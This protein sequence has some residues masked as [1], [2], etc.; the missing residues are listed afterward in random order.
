[1]NLFPTAEE[2]LEYTAAAIR[3]GAVSCVA[4]VER[5]LAAIDAREAEVKAWVS[6][7][8]EGALQRARELD[9]EIAR[10]NWVGPL[11]G[12]PVGIKDIIAVA[13][14]PTGAGSAWHAQ[15]PVSQWDADVV[16]RLRNAGAIILGKTVTTQFASFD[17]PPTHNPWKLDR[18]PG[19]SS[20]G[21]AAAVAT[22]MCLAAIGSQTGGSITR[23]ASFCGVASCKPTFGTVSLDG[24]L[25]LAPSMD[26]PGPMARTVRDVALVLSAISDDFS[27]L[28]VLAEAV[29]YRPSLGKLV[30]FFDDAVDAGYAQLMDETLKALAGAGA[31]IANITGPGVYEELATKHRTVMACEAAAAHRAA[32]EEHRDEY[33]PCIKTLIEEGIAT[34]SVDYITAQQHQ[35]A[36]RQ[37]MLGA[38]QQV[39]VLVTPAT[40]GPAPDAATTGDPRMNSVW[41]YLGYPTVSFPIGLSS[42]GLPLAIQLIGRPHEELTLFQIAIWCEAVVRSLHTPHGE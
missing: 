31:F 24:I 22:G 19:G 40:I 5:C 21:S 7:D 8:R 18:T 11:H 42:D 41:S 10:G 30:G 37:S 3:A 34:G 13:N 12:I 28:A 14:T 20:S 6:V 1:M 38:F 35:K 15:L 17:P 26:H 29:Q 23:P 9:A 2:T 33:G 36:M 39:D 25:P 16:V 32:Y 27:Q 4:T